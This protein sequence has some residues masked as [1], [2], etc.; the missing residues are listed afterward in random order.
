MR[1]S[2]SEEQGRKRAAS[3]SLPAMPIMAVAGAKKGVTWTSTKIRAQTAI[4]QIKRQYEQ[5]ALMPPFK[6]KTG[7]QLF[8]MYRVAELKEI[9]PGGLKHHEAFKRAAREWTSFSPKDQDFYNEV[10]GFSFFFLSSF[11]ARHLTCRA[12]THSWQRQI[13]SLPI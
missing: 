8:H 9:T 3:S 13:W 6:K 7:Y 12:R 1:G 10:R 11:L 5:G 2:W 4:T